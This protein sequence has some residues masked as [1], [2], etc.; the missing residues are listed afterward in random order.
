MK[1][2]LLFL[3]LL[4]TIYSRSQTE[5]LNITYNSDFEKQILNKVIN[6]EKYNFQD[7]LLG[8]SYNENSFQKQTNKIKNIKEEL[9]SKKLT[10]KSIKKKIKVITKYINAKYL[11]QFEFD[12]TFDEIFENGKFNTVTAAGLYCILFDHYKIPYTINET[13]TSVNLIVYN[14]ETEIIIQPINSPKGS[15]TYDLDFKKNYVEYL[16][17][18]NL[19]DESEKDNE[20][21]DNLFLN[22]Y[23]AKNI[24]TKTQLGAL[25]YYNKSIGLISAVGNYKEALE[26]IKKA[27][28]LYP[29][30]KISYSYNSLLAQIIN[31]DAA[32]KRY[33]AK[34]IGNFLNLNIDN[35]LESKNINNLLL[36]IG[37]EYLLKNAQVKKFEN[38]FSEL[39]ET[40]LFEV[41]FDMFQETYHTLFASYYYYLNDYTKTLEQL[42][43]VL[44]INSNN[45][46]I[47]GDIETAFNHKLLKI[48]NTNEAISEF[49][50]YFDMFPFLKENEYYQIEYTRL[51]LKKIYFAYLG[52]DFI[53][54]KN[55]IDEFKIL[56]SENPDFKYDSEYIEGAFMTAAAAYDKSKKNLNKL[57]NFLETGLKYAPESMALNKAY[58]EIESYR[59]LRQ[60]MAKERNKYGKPTKTFSEKINEFFKTCW[61]VTKIEKV[62]DDI[63]DENIL[64]FTIDIKKNKVVSFSSEKRSFEGEWSIRYNSELLYLVPKK[65][66]NN[67]L[68]YKISGI[69]EDELIL[70]PFVKGKMTNRILT[71]TKCK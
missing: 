20:N 44:I 45:L 29:N 26:H 60:K 67:Y 19:I 66:R 65:N 64:D 49:K 27:Y 1:I 48:T 41:E 13:E 28:L 16:L 17:N 22:Y 52:K 4:I 25:Q 21:V 10:S 71:L 2:K 51:H 35:H 11:R 55:S 36:T 58:N 14:G 53:S 61:T 37:D 23:K 9:D 33:N 3:F 39:K 50:T 8:I 18:N 34:L 57:I 30:N 5:D 69:N 32:N 43:E 42:A 31:D 56:M 62:G 59:Q 54:G 15:L 47:K 63:S 40:V 70:R 24:I 12:A 68:V 7:F 46:K 6:V 38:F